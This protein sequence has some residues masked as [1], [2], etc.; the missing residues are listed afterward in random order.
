MNTT[1]IDLLSGSLAPA[2]RGI[3]NNLPCSDSGADTA[4]DAVLHT[5]PGAVI[6]LAI[7][8]GIRGRVSR[9]GVP[10]SVRE[11]LRRLAQAGEP[12][13]AMVLDWLDDMLL[14]D[15]EGTAKTPPL[16]R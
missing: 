4:S 12:A 7:S 11:N 8:Y 6:G 3:G 14:A 15:L 5:D 9:E 13:C 10:P 16:L 1:K 2:N